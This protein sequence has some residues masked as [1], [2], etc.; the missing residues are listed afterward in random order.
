MRTWAF[1]KRGSLIPTVEDRNLLA[2]CITVFQTWCFFPVH[3]VCYNDDLKCF[4]LLYLNVF[5]ATSLVLGRFGEVVKTKNVA[6]RKRD[7]IMNLTAWVVNHC[8]HR[9]QGHLVC[10]RETIIML[11]GIRFSLQSACTK[12]ATD[13]E[14][15]LDPRTQNSHK[16]NEEEFIVF[17]CWFTR[18]CLFILISLRRASGDSRKSVYKTFCSKQQSIITNTVWT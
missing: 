5:L 10:S 11:P 6:W 7:G 3:L 9:C 17:L 4:C 8:L 13:S 14:G 16:M 1:W 12:S 2:V 15:E 18:G